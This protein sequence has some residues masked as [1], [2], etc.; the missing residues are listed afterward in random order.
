[1]NSFRKARPLR[2]AVWSGPRNIST[3]TMRSWGNRTD[4]AVVDEPFYAHYLAAT[5]MQHPG[6]DEV[7]AYQENDWLKVSEQL[8]GPVPGGKPIFYQKHMAHHLLPSMQGDWLN[9]LKHVFLIR[10]PDAMLLSLD[11]VLDKPTLPDTGLPQQL[12][13]FEQLKRDSGPETGPAPIVIDSAD[14]LRNPEG[15]LR[16][17]CAHLNVD[18]TEDMLSWPPGP[19]DT[20]GIWAKHW[21]AKVEQSS[22]FKPYREQVVELP[23]NLQ[24]VHQA[25]L[26]Y[27]QT[28]YEQRLY[29]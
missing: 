21:Y 29:V 7:L 18:F 3:A 15:M 5:G 4:I 10:R 8:L 9:E 17:W 16:A 12:A 20:D 28:L 2:L 14:V 25:C 1:M 23:E 6:R 22:G 13:L 24:S 11:K 19:R 27:Y 26:P